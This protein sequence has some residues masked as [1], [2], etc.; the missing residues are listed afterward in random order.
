MARLPLHENGA[1]NWE[2]SPFTEGSTPVMLLRTIY[3]N[4]L[5]GGLSRSVRTA[6]DSMGEACF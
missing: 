5:P 3:W 6:I 1:C 4:V 2:Q